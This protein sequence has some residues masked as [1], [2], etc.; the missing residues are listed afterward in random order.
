[1]GGRPG[2]EGKILSISA[3]AAPALVVTSEA[4][5]AHPMN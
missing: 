1:V 3:V 2:S 4:V 5:D